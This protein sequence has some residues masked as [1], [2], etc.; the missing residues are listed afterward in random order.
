MRVNVTSAAEGSSAFFE[1]K[2]RPVLVAAHSVLGVV[3]FAALDERDVTAGAVDAVAGVGQAAGTAG[4]PSGCQ[5]SQRSV[6][7]S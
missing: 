4:S 1:M 6:A 5:S 3:A 2:S 7:G